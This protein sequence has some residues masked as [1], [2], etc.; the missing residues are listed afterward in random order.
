MRAQLGTILEFIGYWFSVP[1]LIGMERLVKL[2]DRIESMLRLFPWLG[3]AYVNFIAVRSVYQLYGS[4]AD[5]DLFEYGFGLVVFGPA[6]VAV[7]F[8]IMVGVRL[9]LDLNSLMFARTLFSI[10]DVTNLL[11]EMWDTSL[12]AYTVHW[13]YRCMAISFCVVIPGAL[14]WVAIIVASSADVSVDVRLGALAVGALLVYYYV[15]MFTIAFL[16]IVAIG[17]G[18]LT[19]ITLLL[20]RLLI[21]LA[22]NTTFHKRAV[23][24]TIAL[25]VL[26]MFLQTVAAGSTAER[27]GIVAEIVAFGLLLPELLEPIPRD[28]SQRLVQAGVAVFFGGLM[29]QLW[30]PVNWVNRIGLI[31]GAVSLVVALPAVYGPNAFD[32]VGVRP[33]LWRAL[34]LF[35]G[36]VALQLVATFLP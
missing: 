17:Y 19:G 36:G 20:K 14:I 15:V 18:I 26:G 23:W 30:S 3:V 16:G 10:G 27:L 5:Q 35:I 33:V 22:D 4:I 13:L 12:K 11:E 32:E 25:S 31:A 28:W 2:E 8:S 24:W 7:L 21:D 6:I 29:L 1:V 34:W 9:L